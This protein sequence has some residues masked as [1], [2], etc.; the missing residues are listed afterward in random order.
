M[1]GTKKKEG[2]A[3]RA[4][5]ACVF[6]GLFVGVLA[7]GKWLG[8]ELPTWKTLNPRYG[9]APFPSISNTVCHALL[10]LLFC[11]SQQL[12]CTHASSTFGI[13]VLFGSFFMLSNFHRLDS[14]NTTRVAEKKRIENR[15]P[16][17]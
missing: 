16:L 1:C 3:S 9:W 14:R 12:R 10:P 17:I 15:S 7:S 6:F 2:E 11:I 13:R 8:C 5:G 4:F